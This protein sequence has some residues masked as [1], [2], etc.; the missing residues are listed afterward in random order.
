M[1]EPVTPALPVQLT[2]PNAQAWGVYT[3]QLRVRDDSDAAGGSTAALA[4]APGRRRDS[5]RSQARLGRVIRV[6]VFDSVTVLQQ[7]SKLALYTAKNN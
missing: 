6:T 7:L 3:H 2:E 5:P 4:R 1:R